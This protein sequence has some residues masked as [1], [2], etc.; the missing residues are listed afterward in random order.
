MRTIK[1]IH[2]PKVIKLL[3]DPI[4]REILR[5]ISIQPL[6][7]T[8]LSERLNLKK[9]S[10]G[11]HLQALRE[12]G[13]IKISRRKVGSHGI[14]EK[15]YSPTASFFIID[16][17]K[18]PSKLRMYF[19]Y[20]H[21]ERLRGMLSAFQLLAEEKGRKIKVTSEELM[22]LAHEVA[23]QM[24]K[25]GRKY[26]KTENHIDREM[27]IIKIY[28]ETLRDV[29]LAEEKW[30]E[31]REALEASSSNDERSWKLRPLSTFNSSMGIQH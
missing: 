28:S 1:V 8:R 29:L 22:E 9:P 4:R 20:N 25:I 16:W 2:D 7:E 5:S 14:Q 17:E 12:A 3:A 26:E 30:R 23:K 19:L 11:Y 15:F 10:I 27:L 6:T 21:L 24:P 13:L 31:L 18:V